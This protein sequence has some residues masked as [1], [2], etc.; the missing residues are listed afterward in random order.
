MIVSSRAGHLLSSRRKPATERRGRGVAVLSQIPLSRQQCWH[1]PGRSRQCRARRPGRTP[2][3]AS[4]LSRSTS[5]NSPAN[6]LDAVGAAGRFDGCFERRVVPRSGIVASGLRGN[7]GSAS[8]NSCATASPISIASPWSGSNATSSP[9]RADGALFGLRRAVDQVE[10]FGQNPGDRVERNRCSVCSNTASNWRATVSSVLPRDHPGDQFDHRPRAGPAIPSRN[11]GPA[12]CVPLARADPLADTG[13]RPIRV[14]GTHRENSGRRSWTASPR[15]AGTGGSAGSV[16]SPNA[17]SPARSASA[18]AA[19]SAAASGVHSE[20]IAASAPRSGSWCRTGCAPAPPAMR[21]HPPQAPPR[22][23]RS[24]R[25]NLPPSVLPRVRRSDPRFPFR[26][27]SGRSRANIVATK[28]RTSR[29]D[30]GWS[31]FSRCR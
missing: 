10:P 25:R 14:T 4:P 1:A 16:G 2:P 12:P 19:R 17:I 31:P 11:A 13:P 20:A 23:R 7:G 6:G 3:H 8:E 29:A 5:R 27:A 26:V 22:R 18:P 21:R 30:R 15:R 9:T 24:G 28:R